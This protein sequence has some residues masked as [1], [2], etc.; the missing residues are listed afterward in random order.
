MKVISFDRH[1]WQRIALAIGLAILSAVLLTLAFPPHN[2]GFLIW[3][4]FIPMLIAQYRILPL[5]ISSLASAIAIGGWLGVLLV[6]MFGGKSLF[7]A[8]IPLLAGLLVFLVDKN[9]RAFHERTSYRWFV[10]EG[11]VGW[12]GLEMLRSFIPAI[13]TWL[14]VGYPLWNNPWLLQPLSIFGI[15]GLD[16]LIMLGNYAMAQGLFVFLDRF[17]WNAGALVIDLRHALYWL[18]GFLVLGSAWTGCSL[19]LYSATNQPGPVVRVA[20]IQPNLPR[21][22]HRDTVTSLDQRLAIL[23]AQSR[24]AAIQGAQAI[25]WPEMALG[26]DPQV[27]HTQELVSLAADMQAYIVIGYVLDNKH[28][29]RNEATVLAPSGQ[30]LGVYGKVHP[31]ISSGEPRTT[32]AGVYPVYETSFGRLAT[33]ICFDADFTDVARRL[34]RHGAQFIAVPSLFGRSIAQM[35]HTQIVFRAIENRVAIV[36]ADVAYNSVIVDPF[37]RVLEL[38]ITPVGEQ[39]TLVVDVPLG[40]GN[41]FYARFGDWL[42]WLSLGGLAFFIV[43]MPIKLG[44]KTTSVVNR[45]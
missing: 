41:T 25:V 11:V 37:G 43:F 21:A 27:E 34:S 5:K 12:V 29:F 33:M 14:F 18:I 19:L 22:A 1:T 40:K 39:A 15:Y 7:M 17:G 35:P 31:M 44:K 3:V 13:G 4:G 28:G 23:S 38:A 20:A 26:F 30:F 16:L 8:A 42:G 2:L 10:V 32:S 9:K 36:M 24:Q 45:H 6:P